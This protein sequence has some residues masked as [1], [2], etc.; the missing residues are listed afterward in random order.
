MIR[1]FSKILKKYPISHN[2]AGCL[3]FGVGTV[4]HA[5]GSQ[6][7]PEMIMDDYFDNLH[8]PDFQSS[9]A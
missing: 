1:N 2:C 4:P 7:I 3:S 5:S 8:L 6:I 9:E